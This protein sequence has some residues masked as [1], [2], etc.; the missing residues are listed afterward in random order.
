MSIYINISLYIKIRHDKC[1]HNQFINYIFGR[2]V[3]PIHDINK[4]A[5]LSEQYSFNFHG[6]LIAMNLSIAIESIT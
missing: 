6:Y 1:V 5:L 3:L 2:N 4:K